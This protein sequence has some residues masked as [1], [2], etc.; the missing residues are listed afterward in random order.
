[1]FNN[2]LTEKQKSNPYIQNTLTGWHFKVRKNCFPLSVIFLCHEIKSEDGRKPGMGQSFRAETCADLSPNHSNDT[3]PM[4]AGSQ[5]RKQYLTW[6][7]V[8]KWCCY[9]KWEQ[10][11]T[12]V[13]ETVQ[14]GDQA[15]QLLG[16]S[17]PFVLTSYLFSHWMYDFPWELKSL[18]QCQNLKWNERKAKDLGDPERVSLLWFRCG[19]G[20]MTPIKP[21]IWSE[22]RE[23]AG[24]HSHDAQPGLSS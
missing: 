14:T 11:E 3:E 9:L 16:K 10:L 19:V 24:S 21:L 4:S 13:R 22:G 6:W 2:I 8:R 15:N 18:S 7:V 17:L 20:A 12:K 23:T 1:M 5:L